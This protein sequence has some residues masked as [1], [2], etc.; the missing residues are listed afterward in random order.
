P[1]ITS[2]LAQLPRWAALIAGMIDL[3]K[4]LGGLLVGV[5]R[6]RAAREAEMAFLRQQLVVLQRSA[7]ARLRL[8]TADRLILSGSIGCSLPCSKPRL[9]SSLRRWCAGIG[10]ASVCTGVASR[11]VVSAGL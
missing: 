3:L 11:A 1:K 7:P 10:A 8:R 2:G 4:L 9:S 5:F 6:S